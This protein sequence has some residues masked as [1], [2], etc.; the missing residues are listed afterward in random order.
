MAK[1]QQFFLISTPTSCEKLVLLAVTAFKV[2]PSFV[3]RSPPSFG[4]SFMLIYEYEGLFCF[5]KPAQQVP[6][7]HSNSLFFEMELTAAADLYMFEIF[8]N[9]LCMG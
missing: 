5:P 7:A 3:V 6:P 1:N 9:V 8:Q 4:R 2:P